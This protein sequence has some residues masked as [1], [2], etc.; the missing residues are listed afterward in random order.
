M[1]IV[2]HVRIQNPAYSLSSVIFF[3]HRGIHVILPDSRNQFRSKKREKKLRSKV[4]LGVAVIAVTAVG[5]WQWS[6]IRS[7]FAKEAAPEE[8]LEALWGGQRYEEIN[9]VSEQLLAEDPL[10]LDAL[11]YNGF[12]YFYRGVN[13]FSFEEKIALFDRCISNLRKAIVLD[14]GETKGSALYVLGK[15]YYYKGKYYADLTIEYLL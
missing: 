8:T 15:A 7:L 1:T 4:I 13:Q 2:R 3:R 5:I 10:R 12:S 9:A 11:L 6:N 14:I